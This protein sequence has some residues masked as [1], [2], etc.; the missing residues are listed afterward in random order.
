MRTVLFYLQSMIV[1]TI[2]R[3]FLANP[4]QLLQSF[5]VDRTLMM[6]SFPYCGYAFDKFLFQFLEV[7]N[8][9]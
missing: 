8:V 1:P 2:H 9:R 4:A 3:N 6:Q 5:H 7:K